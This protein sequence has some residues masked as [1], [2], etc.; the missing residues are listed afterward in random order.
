[1]KYRSNL[2]I[3]IALTL[4]CQLNASN[5]T[6]TREVKLP[7]LESQ[8]YYN[9]TTIETFEEQCISATITYT[10][11]EGSS[12]TDSKTIAGKFASASEASIS[13]CNQTGMNSSRVIS[14]AL[15]MGWVSIQ[16]TGPN[17]YGTS[18]VQEYGAYPNPAPWYFKSWI[19]GPPPTDV[20][21]GPPTQQTIDVPGSTL[22][23]KIITP[24]GY[25]WILKW[26]EEKQG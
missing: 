17:Q 20:K 13:Y 1:M 2:I 10:I 18:S 7:A 26:I 11:S 19:V 4:T 8:G 24:Q 21:N 25:N 14:S 5:D 3:L 12:Q 6:M 23:R 22:Q 15:N 16:T 9:I